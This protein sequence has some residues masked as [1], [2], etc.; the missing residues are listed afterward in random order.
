M[1]QWTWKCRTFFKIVISFP[2]AIYSEEGLLHHMVVLFLFYCILKKTFFILGCVGSSSLCEGPLQLWRAGATL[3][4]SE[5]APHYRDLS[6]CGAQAP[7]AQA[8]PLR[9]MWD[10]PRPGL[11]PV[12]PALAG[13][14]STTATPGKPYCIF[15]QFLNWSIVDLQCCVNF[16]CTKWF[17]YTH[18]YIF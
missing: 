15:Y 8:Q 13:R 12:S 7:D 5:R 2:W 11:E 6:C 9:S 4:R 17:S 3:H 14:F 18:I 1:L 10:P 16:C